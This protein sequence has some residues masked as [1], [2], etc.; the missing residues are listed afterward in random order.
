MAASPTRR[1]P[2]SFASSDG[3]ALSD[4][5]D[6]SLVLRARENPSDD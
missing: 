5:V 4:E 3:R 2:D 6:D 1:S